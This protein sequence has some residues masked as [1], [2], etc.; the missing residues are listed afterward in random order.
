MKNLP[1]PGNG[2]QGGKKHVHPDGCHPGENNPSPRQAALMLAH[3]RG[4]GP[5]TGLLYSEVAEF[6]ALPQP[7]KSPRQQKQQQ[8]KQGPCTFCK[9]RHNFADC[10]TMWRKDLYADGN[11]R[12]EVFRKLHLCFNCGEADHSTGEC[13]HPKAKCVS[14]CGG[15]HLDCLHVDDFRPIQV[16]QRR[17]GAPTFGDYLPAANLVPS[18]P[19]L[20]APTAPQLPPAAPSVVPLLD[21]NLMGEMVRDAGA[22]AAP[23]HRANF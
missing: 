9:G 20:P 17:G 11:Q 22:S 6:P 16:E 1:S 13:P 12:R 7:S 14:F 4:Q 18:A 15:R 2:G 8:R 19:T 10:S 5:T 21:K 3:A 23:R